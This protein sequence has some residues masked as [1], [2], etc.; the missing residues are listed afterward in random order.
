[1][2][3][4]HNK[5]RQKQ[6]NCQSWRTDGIPSR[7]DVI[8]SVMEV[9]VNVPVDEVLTDHCRENGDCQEPDDRHSERSRVSSEFQCR[10]DEEE[11]VQ[12]IGCA[13]AKMMFVSWYNSV[14][15]RFS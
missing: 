15:H 1:M 3:V 4:S 2:T 11:D 9:V 8:F 13:M 7:T 6:E 5:T 12:V 14:H 10:Q